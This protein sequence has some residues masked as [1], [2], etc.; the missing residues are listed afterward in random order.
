MKTNFLYFRENGSQTF[1]AT[2]AQ[3]NFTI[4][5]DANWDLNVAADTEVKV[6][7]TF[8]EAQTTKCGSAYSDGAVD[9][10][11][12]VTVN[13]S[14]K[15]ISTN[16]IVIANQGADG[17]NGITIS[18]GDIVTISLIPVEGTEACFRADR[19]LAVNS[20]SDTST[21]LKFKSSNGST[22]DDTVTLTHPDNDGAEFKLIADYIYEVCNANITERGNVITCW[23][24]QN[25]VIGRGLAKAGVTKMLLAIA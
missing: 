1:V 25:N 13:N 12:T 6:E 19:L 11:E 9:A 23:D 14:G 8:L 16:D 3:T 24:K 10:G 21:V 22:A 15:S 18:A 2:D 5:G 20:A 7:V 4:N 17:T